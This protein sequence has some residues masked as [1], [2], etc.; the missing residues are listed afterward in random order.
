MAALTAAARQEIQRAFE[1]AAP[2]ATAAMV[3]KLAAAFGVSTS[4]IYRAAQRGGKKRARA[5]RRPEYREWARMAALIA[6]ASPERPLPLD[7]AL[8]AGVQSGALPPE[9]AAM[10]IG[11]AYRIIRELGFTP[12]ARRAR[13][14]FADYP[15]QA[16]QVDG[17]GSECLMAE[18]ALADGD[19]LLKLNT[20]PLPSGG[21]KNKP[22]GPE[23]LRVWCYGLWDMATGYTLSRYAVAAGESS[24]D[25]MAFLCWALGAEHGDPRVPFHG[26][27]D[28]LWT[29]QGPLFKSAASRE[30]LERLGINLEAGAPYNKNRMGGVERS[31]RA[32][33]S[34]FESSLFA[35]G[36]E[37]WTLAALNARLLEFHIREND[38][39]FSRARVGGRNASRADAWTALTNAR[40]ADN[41]LRKLPADP[42]ATMAREARRWA[43][44]NGVIRWGGVEYELPGD[45]CNQWV[46]A[47]RPAVARDGEVANSQTSASGA[48][49]V[50]VETDGGAR[51]MA[52][53][54]QA[55]PYGQ[56]PPAATPPL[57]RALAD[58]PPAVAADC[59][60]PGAARRD[61]GAT[62]LPARSGPAAPLENPL[63]ASRHATPEEA[64]QAFLS[65]YGRPLSAARLAQAR[66][67]LARHN[68]SKQAARDLAL[69]MSS[70]VAVAANQEE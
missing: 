31:H 61:A 45:L 67:I 15:M 27:P 24:L 42:I 64:M 43:D 25:A 63:D 58:G 66:A 13:R 6:R 46:T 35:A 50:V 14:L 34:R 48:G 59:Y 28:N 17:S 22:L 36:R 21:Y 65:L 3:R 11:T 40:P 37:T 62:P 26:V 18:R 9:A 60:A 68:F 12:R 51:V 55:R 19:F 8:E 41:R 7:L 5:P 56:T 54:L 49:P 23:R 69:D 47:R 30:L 53:P 44:A 4:T 57:E 70:L 38:L 16:V 32:R 33:W 1:A 2:G 29:D 52:A 20:T 10:P 39:R